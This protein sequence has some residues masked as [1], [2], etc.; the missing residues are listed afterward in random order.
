MIRFIINQKYS[1]F[2]F[3]FLIMQFTFFFLVLFSAIPIFLYR[4]KAQSSYDFIIV[5]YIKWPDIFLESALFTIL[6]FSFSR[7]FRK[8]EFTALTYAP[9]VW[10][11]KLNL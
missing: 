1:P 5:F 7:I 4:L 8:R 3:S 2:H 9:L 6:P 11:V 10:I